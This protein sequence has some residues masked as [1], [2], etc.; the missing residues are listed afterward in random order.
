MT[1]AHKEAKRAAIRAVY[2][3]ISAPDWAAPNLDGLADVLRD[4]SWLP[5]GPVELSAPDISALGEDDGQALLRV[6]A[7][8]AAETA[9]SERPV[10]FVPSGH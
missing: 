6:L 7:R 8:A 1:A 10:R 2:A 9:G 5:A 3:Q 4:L